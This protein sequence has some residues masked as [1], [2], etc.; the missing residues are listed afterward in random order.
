MDHIN[1][2]FNSVS[3]LAKTLLLSLTGSEKALGVNREMQEH[4]PD[5]EP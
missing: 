3:I 4:R 1:P 2:P 5:R